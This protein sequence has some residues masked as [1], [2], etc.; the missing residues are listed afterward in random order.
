VLV[1][2]FLKVGNRTLSWCAVT[3]GQALA[4]GGHPIA[5]VLEMGADILGRA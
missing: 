4:T 2:A 3:Q 1:F 5:A